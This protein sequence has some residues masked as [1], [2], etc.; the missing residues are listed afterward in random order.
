ML[1]RYFSREILT[2]SLFVLLALL[3]LFGFFDLIRELDDLG[4]GNYR[5]NAMLMYVSLTLP[6]HAYVLMPAAGLI[7]TLFALARMSE[8]SEITVMR[9]SGLSMGQLALHVVGAGVVIAVAT[10]VI[11]ELVA[12]LS[13]ETAKDLRLK[14]TRSIVAREFRSGFWVKDDRSFVNIQDV[15]PDTELLN[16]RI[17]EFDPAY[18]LTAI[19]RAEKG[20]YKGPNEWTL[21]NVELTRFQ[22][23][24]A[25]LER[26]PQAIWHSV[27]APDIL[28]VLKIVPERMSAFSLRAYIDHLRENRQNATRYEIAFWNKLMYPLAAIAMMVMAIP[29]AL[30]SPRAGGAGTKIVMGILLGL[31]FH[32]AGRLFSHIG[33]LNDWPAVAAAAIPTAI[34]ALV[35]FYGLRRAEVR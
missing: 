1:F 6:S 35:A 23:D 21:T 10:V 13:E 26:L 30:G 12:P 25:T 24:R 32:F 31:A 18:R 29:F 34:V 14:A 27:L 4:R 7:G 16:L 3:A 22:G 33:L 8:N 17:Y 9:A 15:T 28:A 2:T 5:L 11:G 19:S 20:T